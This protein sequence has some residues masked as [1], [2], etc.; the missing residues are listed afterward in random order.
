MAIA[1]LF[2]TAVHRELS[3]GVDGQNRRGR[4]FAVAGGLFVVSLGLTTLGLAVAQWI[5]A[6]SL[7]A[8]VIAITIANAFAAIVRFAV[9]RAWI[10]RPN[11]RNETSLGPPPAAATPPRSDPEEPR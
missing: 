7:L 9:L 6:G 2:N 11:V 4:F 5:A 3:R 8:D 1:T 10:F